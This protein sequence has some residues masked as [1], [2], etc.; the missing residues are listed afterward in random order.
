MLDK[1]KIFINFEILPEIKEKEVK[2]ELKNKPTQN[3]NNYIQWCLRFIEF[4]SFFKVMDQQHDINYN[5]V[6]KSGEIYI[7]KKAYTYI[8][9]INLERKRHIDAI[10]KHKN[11]NLEF[12]LDFSI[13]HYRNLENFERCAFL[14]KIKDILKE[15][16]E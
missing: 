2:E 16:L 7:N 12:C 11:T 3:L 8:K 15:N 1:N 9:Y 5:F 14:K 10:K 13:E 6:L 4:R